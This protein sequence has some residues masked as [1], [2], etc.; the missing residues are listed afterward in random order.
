MISNIKNPGIIQ[1][2]DWDKVRERFGLILDKIN[3]GLWED[4]KIHDPLMHADVYSMDLFGGVTISR[5]DDNAP[6]EFWN[7]PLFESL[8][9]WVA[10]VRE[11]LALSGLPIGTISYHR[12]TTGISP[13][14][15]TGY[16]GELPDHPHTNINFLISS[17]TPDESYTWCR[18]DNDNEMRYYSHP[19][20]LW[21]LNASNIHS[22]VCNG[23]R[24]G[25]T[26]K[27]RQP[28]DKVDKFFKDN[29]DFFDVSQPYF[30]Q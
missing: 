19:N 17:A 23:F 20:K 27:F 21:I 14:T 15:D 26:I 6:W 22:V 1:T 3:D 2:S 12:H 10:A 29:P 5:S 25:L 9:P 8:I 16:F 4:K 18:D 24:E 11:Q 30:K 13:H 28:Y 7:G